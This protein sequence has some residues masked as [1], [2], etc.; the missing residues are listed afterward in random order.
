[1]TRMTQRSSDGEAIETEIDRIQSLGLDDLRTLWRRLD[2][3]RVQPQFRRHVFDCAVAAAPADVIGKALG[4]ERIVG[5]KV[6]P[7][8]L[9]LAAAAAGGSWPGPTATRDNVPEAIPQPVDL[10]MEP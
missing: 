6:E 7:L 5:Q 4:G 2:G 3:V 1:M 9:H 10:A 8:A